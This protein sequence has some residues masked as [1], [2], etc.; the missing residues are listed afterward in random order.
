MA[1]TGRILVLGAGIYQVPLIQ[2][3]QQMGLEAIVVSR[4]GNY[5]G[6]SV[7][8][9][10]LPLDTT[11]C[12]GILEAAR[13][14]SVDG[15]ITTGTDVAMR[16]IGRVCD[17]LGLS[18]LSER[19]AMLATDK[20]LMKDAFAK[21]GVSTSPFEVV[22]SLGDALSAAA[23]IG[24]PVMVKACDVSGSRG[25][26]KVG[27]PE[28]LP[29]AHEEA[30]AATRKDY[31]VVEGFVSGHEIGVDAYVSQ[32]EL[33][34]FAPHTKFVRRAGSVTVP[35]GHAFPIAEG[36]ETLAEIRRQTKLSIET[37]GLDNCAVN[38]D[39]MVCDDGTVSVL[40]V[41]GRCGATCIPE[42]I[43]I[44]LGIDYYRQMIRGALGE[45]PDLTPRCNKPCM[46]KLLFS[47][48]SGIVRS[49][50]EAGLSRLL[51]GH[52]EATVS[53]DVSVGDE[54]CAIRNG[55]DRWGQVIM[56]TSSEAELD[57]MVS[58]VRS[59]VEVA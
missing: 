27:S 51:Q 14:L 37:L 39:F 21:G 22:R 44:H 58:A 59:C 45:R 30:R 47:Q 57:H 33:V 12:A 32:G 5:P 41:G 15:I 18:G 9:R 3:A 29:R 7:A 24:Y 42:L 1:G 53:L 4:P 55:T 16:S 19:A 25:I 23:S 26:S 54:V 38:G 50:D 11:D 6:F 35:E 17:A 8:D 28:E 56:E 34:L 43:S 10:S 49:I 31:V 20:A 48:T 40:E 13:E 36:P 52:P 2:T 46:A